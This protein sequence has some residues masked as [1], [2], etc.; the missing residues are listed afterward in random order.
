MCAKVHIH[1]SVPVPERVRVQTHMY[2]CTQHMRTRETFISNLNGKR[3]NGRHAKAPTYLSASIPV[4]DGYVYMHIYLYV[5][6]QYLQTHEK[7]RTCKPL[8]IYL[9][10]T[11][12]CTCTYTC[13]YMYSTYKPMKIYVPVNHWKSR[14]PPT[15]PRHKLAY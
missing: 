7:L 9:Y 3:Q 15:T 12:T 11:C 1:A 5:Y 4:L 8:C 13:A 10:W 14:L 2:K 6:V